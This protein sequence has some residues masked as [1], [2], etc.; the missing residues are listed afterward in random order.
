MTDFVKIHSKV[1]AAKRERSAETQI[2]WGK[3]IQAKSA[4][5][6]FDRFLRHQPLEMHFVPRQSLA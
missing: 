4:V 2:G 5:G 6:N 1:Y 3:K